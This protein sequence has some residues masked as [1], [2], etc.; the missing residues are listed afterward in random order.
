M[1]TISFVVVTAKEIPKLLKRFARYDP[2]GR[3]GGITLRQFLDIPEI[4]TNPIMPKVASAYLERRTNRLTSQSFINILS[5]LSPRNSLD[6]KKQCEYCNNYVEGQFILKVK[7]IS[8]F[9]NINL[10]N[11][12]LNFS[13]QF[14]YFSVFGRL[15]KNIML[16]NHSVSS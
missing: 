6:D 16:T 15:S 14:V 8:T 5:R 7:M 10:F 9:S 12:G 13:N 4:S 2:E 1:T 3:N 11:A